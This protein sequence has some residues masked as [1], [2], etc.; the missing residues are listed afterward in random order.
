VRWAAGMVVLV[1][2][3]VGIVFATR[4]DSDPTLVRSARLGQPAPALAL[5]LLDGE[6]GAGGARPTWSIGDAKGQIVVVNFWASW[7][8]PCRAEHAALTAA[9]E[10]Y[11]DDGVELV[12]ILHNDSE[13]A[14]RAFLDDLGRGY[15]SVI[16]PGSR[17]AIDYG[18]RGVPE[19]FFVDRDGVIVGN[20]LGPVD[21]PLLTRTLDQMLLGG[22]PGSRRTGTVRTGPED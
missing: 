5:P 18:V 11:A 13:R 10:Q 21:L 4:F 2:A 6:A 16:D 22:Q 17:A 20:V 9:A 8:V 7:C 1:V 12:G 3:M 14:A 19:T 15:P